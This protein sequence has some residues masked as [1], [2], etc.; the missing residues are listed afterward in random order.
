M[1]AY[2]ENKDH[3]FLGQE[4]ER[5]QNYS[6]Q[7]AQR[8]DEAIH[9]IITEQYDRALTLLNKHRK[10]LDVCA[11]ALLKHE[12]IDGSH[13]QEILEFGE[14]RSSVTKR[15]PVAPDPEEANEGKG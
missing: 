6:E 10:E 3:V 4:I 7:T 5:T 15:E 13:I 2:G 8:V 12:T 14:I 9:R 1:V 11:E